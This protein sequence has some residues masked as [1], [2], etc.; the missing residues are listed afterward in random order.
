MSARLPDYLLDAPFQGLW[1]P[2]PMFDTEG[3]GPSKRRAPRG[4]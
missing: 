3:P 4:R 1:D 2:N